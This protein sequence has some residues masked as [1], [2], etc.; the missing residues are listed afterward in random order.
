MCVI[1]M[2]SVT[3]AQKAKE[4][5]NSKG[6]K[7]EI[8]RINNS[9]GYSISVYADCMTVKKILGD[10]YGEKDISSW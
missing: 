3:Y 2:P 1:R 7:C 10:K 9:C 4:L 6:Y 5:L 8:T